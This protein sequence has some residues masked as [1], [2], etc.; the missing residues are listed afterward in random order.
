MI[1]YAKGGQIIAYKK[2]VPKFNKIGISDKYMIEAINEIGLQD[3]KFDKESIENK[4]NSEFEELLKDTSNYLISEDSKAITNTIENEI[5]TR[6]NQGDTEE[7][8]NYYKKIL[9]NPS[10]RKSQYI[11]KYAETQKETINEWTSYMKQSE[12]PISIKFLIF[13]SVLNFNYDYKLNDLIKRN[14]KTIRNFTPFDAGSLSELVSS[15]SENLLKDYTQIQIENSAKIIKNKELLKTSGNG[16]WLKFNGGSKTSE[17]ERINNSK[18]LAQLVQNTYWCTKTNSKSQLDGGDFYVY[19]TETN[20]EVFPRI[21]IRMDEDN[22]GEVRGNKSSAQDIE[23]EMLPIA[24]KFLTENITNGSGKKWLDGIKY[25]QEAIDLYKKINEEGL[26]KNS[27]EIF[28]K[29]KSKEKENLLDYAN[30]NGHIVRIEK[31]IIDKFPSLPNQYYEEK[32]V[33]FFAN[34]FD[35]KKTKIIIG[36]A[37][38]SVYQIT[39]LGQLTTI[40]GNARFTDSKITDLGKLTTIGGNA[41]FT[42]S[43]ITDLGQLT[44]I[45]GNAIFTDS[46]ITDLGQLTT[47]RGNARFTDSKITDLGKLTTIGG[48]ADFE[49][50][51]ITDLGQL[52]TIGR[53]SYFAYSKITD[54]GKLITIGGNAD[55]TDSKITDL[56]QLTTIGGGAYFK[57]SEITDLGKLT[58]IRG[59]AE[60]RNSIVTDLG[61]LTTIGRD[62]Y[63]A[64]SKITDLGQLKKIGGTA[65]FGNLEELEEKWKIRQENKQ[66]DLE[67]LTN[68]LSVSND[69]LDLISDTG[70]VG[71]I[72]FLKE[73]IKMT[74]DLISLIDYEKLSKG[75]EVSGINTIAQIWE[76]FGI[77]F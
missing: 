23:E 32:E 37:Y 31:I 72:Y 21:A 8:I 25:N 53:D 28:L 20:G 22:V 54:L 66:T 48:N 70:E 51:E 73:K 2:D 39:N 59:D 38:F 26:F 50:S 62:S 49:N 46:E 35:D 30:R 29:L 47:I 45:G 61:K 77:K 5:E 71:D 10:Q 7:N 57:N 12:Y 11:D 41:D 65:F 16:T 34:D 55:F 76:W 13:K 14:N 60:F 67:Y 33:V 58:T 4:I 9:D 3:V 1:N 40:G 19:V 75:G 69:L 64:Y 56:G 68:L 18:E 15:E 43:K 63:F 6:Y 17:E 52:T 74:K 36:D 44:T 42:E 24:E 27:I